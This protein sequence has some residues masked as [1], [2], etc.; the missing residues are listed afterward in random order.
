MQNI[1]RFPQP[2][3][4]AVEPVYYYQGFMSDGNYTVLR[5]PDNPRQII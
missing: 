2:Y 3:M 4:Y 1:S 5:Y